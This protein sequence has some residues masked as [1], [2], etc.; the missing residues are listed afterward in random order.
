MSASGATR[1]AHRSATR[2]YA[3]VG[4]PMDMPERY[5][6]TAPRPLHPQWR[7]RPRLR[8]R[9]APPTTADLVEILVRLREAGADV[10]TINSFPATKTNEPRSHARL[11]HR[12]ARPRADAEARRIAA[13]RSPGVSAAACPA[14]PGPHLRQ[15]RHRRRRWCADRPG[16]AR[17]GRR[18][19]PSQ[20]PRRAHQRRH[21]GT[22]GREGDRRCRPRRGR[23]AAC[24]LLVLAGSIM[25]GDIT[26]AVRELREI[27]HPGRGAL[28]MAGSVSAI[29]DLVVSDPVQAGTMAVMAIADTAQL[30]PGP[31]ARPSLLAIA[32]DRTRDAPYI[33]GA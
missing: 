31:R 1:A 11:R 32:P 14:D 24:A 6:A 23:P 28:S 15:A 21:H 13:L 33:L 2:L 10:V 4:L 7:Q 29:A 25:G 8:S 30:R 16:G 3:I 20:H 9:S 12:A 19:R 17:R 18:E 27:G 26:V 5:R 22:G